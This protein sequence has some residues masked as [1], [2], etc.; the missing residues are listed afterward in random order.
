MTQVTFEFSTKQ[1]KNFSGKEEYAV[2]YA[3]FFCEQALDRSHV[4]ATTLS[5][6]ANHQRLSTNLQ[7]EMQ[8]AMATLQGVF[9][10]LQDFEDFY[11][12]V[13]KMKTIFTDAKKQADKVSSGAIDDYREL[14]RWID[15]ADKV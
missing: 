11:K 6:L 5:T 14:K 15:L 1:L 12:N 3:K 7:A 8:S 9:C 4:A 13:P 10:T 2:S